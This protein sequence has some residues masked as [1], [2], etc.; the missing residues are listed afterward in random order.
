MNSEKDEL[1]YIL[2]VDKDEFRK[3]L[4]E[5]KSLLFLKI[6]TIYFKNKNYYLKKIENIRKESSNEQP[7]YMKVDLKKIESNY[8]NKLEFS[9]LIKLN[10]KLIEVET[11]KYIGEKDIVFS[12]NII[13][14]PKKLNL[15][16][17]ENI[18]GDSFTSDH[19]IQEISDILNEMEIDYIPFNQPLFE[20]YKSRL[21]L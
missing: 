6:K 13:K 5:N 20:L 15:Y 19:S 4:S 2:E 9:K 1:R 18:V 10:Q 17:V 3:H 7:I 11:R 14:Y 16:I 12:E 21:G 8:L